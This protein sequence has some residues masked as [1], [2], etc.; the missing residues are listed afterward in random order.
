MGFVD[1]EKAFD[2]VPRSALIE[3]LLSHFGLSPSI[4]ECIRRMYVEVC[5]TV[6][7][8]DTRVGMTMGVKQGC[9]MSPLLFGLFFDRVVA[10]IEEQVPALDAS[11]MPTDALFIAALAV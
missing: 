3:L 10:F 11:G 7:G 2:T 5:G 8:S 9:P 6:R 1:L 4:V